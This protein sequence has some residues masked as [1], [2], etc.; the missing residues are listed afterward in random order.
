MNLH[1]TVFL[2]E[3]VSALIRDKKGVYVDCTGI[4]ILGSFNNR[5]NTSPADATHHLTIQGAA[6]LGSVEVVNAD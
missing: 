5:T 3:A 2:E 1:Q 4:G 6:I